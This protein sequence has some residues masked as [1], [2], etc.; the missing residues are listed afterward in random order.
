MSKSAKNVKNLVFFCQKIPQKLQKI[1]ENISLHTISP[2]IPQNVQKRP[3][4][5]KILYLKF[6]SENPPK[7]MAENMSSLQFSPIKTQNVQKCPPKV[8]NN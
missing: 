3:K 6:L 4:K 1:C 7:L 2:I 5:L 8:Q